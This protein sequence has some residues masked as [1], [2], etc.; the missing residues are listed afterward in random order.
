MITT[1]KN[2]IMRA[3]VLDKP[4]LLS[5]KQRKIF[6]SISLLWAIVIW[7]NDH[8]YRHYVIEN[9]I[10]DVHIAYSCPSFFSVIAGVFL[11]YSVDKKQCF[12]HWG[13]VVLIEVAC[14]F[15]EVVMSY[16]FDIYDVLATLLGVFPAYLISG[17]VLK[18]MKVYD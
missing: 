15:Y 10:D 9:N 16:T 1:I 11:G 18:I 12:T 4:I 17:L 2:E 7:L 6:F 5:S 3:L 14:L 13:V 8:V